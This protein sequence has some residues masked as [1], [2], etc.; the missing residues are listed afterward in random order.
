MLRE[1]TL[2]QGAKTLQAAVVPGPYLS[3][4]SW[5]S[6]AVGGDCQHAYQSSR[7]LQE[8]IDQWDKQ[9]LAKASARA[10]SSQWAVCVN[11]TLANPSARVRCSQCSQRRSELDVLVV[12]TRGVQVAIEFHGLRER[13]RELRKE[14]REVPS[15]VRLREGPIGVRITLGQP[16]I[17]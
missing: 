2:T 12:T 8:C 10:S 15:R 5:T 16:T 3:G 17:G 14:G 11:L 6:K 9:L 4:G 1:W 13:E 7:Q